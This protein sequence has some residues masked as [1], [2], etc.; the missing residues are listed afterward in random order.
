MSE[1]FEK[2]HPLVTAGV[3]VALAILVYLC[4]ALAAAHQI[5][6]PVVAP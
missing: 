6:A 4:V 3:F 5:Q 2:R 1:D